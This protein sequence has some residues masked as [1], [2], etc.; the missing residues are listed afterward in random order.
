MKDLRHD[1]R[2]AGRPYLLSP[3]VSV[4]RLLIS[5][6]EIIGRWRMKR[7]SSVRKRPIDPKSVI[8]SHLVGAYIR[9]IEGMKSRCRLITTI[10]K[11]SSHM[12]QLMIKATVTNDG[13]RVPT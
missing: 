7:Y 3:S 4:T 2:Q 1:R 13:T 12:P 8:Q 10:T 9:Q 5:K 11:R 6:I